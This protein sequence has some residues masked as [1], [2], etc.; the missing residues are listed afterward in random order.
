MRRRLM[1]PSFHI[2]LALCIGDDE[3]VDVALLLRGWRGKIL[4]KLGF[5]VAARWVLLHREPT[6]SPNEFHIVPVDDGMTH[7]LHSGDCVCGPFGVREK[8][9]D[10][11]DDTWLYTHASLD[12]REIAPT[13]EEL[14][15]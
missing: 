14:T 11:I 6:D 8:H 15:P 9:D 10:G 3:D 7:D 12:A 13:V 1:F 2:H 5:V 4:K